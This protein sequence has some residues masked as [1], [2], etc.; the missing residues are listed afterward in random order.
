MKKPKELQKKAKINPERKKEQIFTTFRRTFDH[1]NNIYKPHLTVKGT[2]QLESI[3]NEKS[4][5]Y[6]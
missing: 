6:L 3:E 2:E 4:F 5:E 1:L